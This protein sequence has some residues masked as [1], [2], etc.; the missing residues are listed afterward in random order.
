MNDIFGNAP[1]SMRQ[2]QKSSCRRADMI[3]RE[4]LFLKFLAT[5]GSVAVAARLAGFSVNTV[6]RKRA[7]LPGFA[8]RWKAAVARQK[9]ALR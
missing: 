5:C 8:A 9:R 7:A 4:A 2:W 6:C 1:V 3:Q